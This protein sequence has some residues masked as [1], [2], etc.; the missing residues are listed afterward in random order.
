MRSTPVEPVSEIEDH[1]I[2]KPKEFGGDVFPVVSRTD[3]HPSEELSDS[4]FSLSKFF[5]DDIL[6]PSGVPQKKSLNHLCHF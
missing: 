5:I 3:F 6:E 1:H 2:P 4:A